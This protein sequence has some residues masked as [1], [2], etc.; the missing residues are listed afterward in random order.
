MAFLLHLSEC[1]CDH[2]GGRGPA[3]ANRAGDLA[4]AGAGAGGTVGWADHAGHAAD[5][6]QHGRDP[7]DS[8]K[9]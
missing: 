7:A 9:N 6:H 8:S 1:S 3:G 4:G 2:A 5:H